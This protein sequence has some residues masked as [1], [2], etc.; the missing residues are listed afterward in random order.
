M[1]PIH[2]PIHYVY[3]LTKH[4]GKF[5]FLAIL[6]AYNIHFTWTLYTTVQPLAILF[7]WIIFSALQCPLCS[8][9]RI[10]HAGLQRKVARFFHGFTYR[11]KIHLFGFTPTTL[12]LITWLCTKLFRQKNISSHS[13]RKNI[14]FSWHSTQR[15]WHLMF[16]LSKFPSS[17]VSPK[18]QC[19]T[20]R[21]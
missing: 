1:H 18:W 5:E 10:N 9:V 11:W 14:S 4:C 19:E 15:L 7:Y 6:K 12:S 20:L 21:C 2:C 16:M 3:I 8:V 17:A 13:V